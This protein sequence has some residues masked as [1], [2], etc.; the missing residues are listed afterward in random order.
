MRSTRSAGTRPAQLCHLLSIA[1]RQPAQLHNQII[2]LGGS[3]L[4]RVG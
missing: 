2:D 1:G 3:E 4:L